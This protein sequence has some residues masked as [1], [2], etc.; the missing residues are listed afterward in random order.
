[1]IV[2]IRK[3]AEFADD[4]DDLNAV[5]ADLVEGVK[6]V[7][8][9]TQRARAEGELSTEEYALLLKLA[10]VN[11]KKRF[12]NIQLLEALFPSLPMHKE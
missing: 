2:K 9:L 12:V 4:L 5:L 7:T 11:D 10:G 3:D 1:M 8:N 6:L